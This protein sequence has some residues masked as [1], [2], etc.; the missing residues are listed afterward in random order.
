MV[1][2]KVCVHGGWWVHAACACHFSL[3]DGTGGVVSA[4]GR[5]KCRSTSQSFQAHVHFVSAFQVVSMADV[6]DDHVDGV[7][8]CRL[9]KVLL[10]FV[11]KAVERH[12]PK[13]RP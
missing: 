9:A 8:P 12:L 5:T 2:S 13:L 4:R 1:D 6:R 11:F 10:R 7:L 3:M